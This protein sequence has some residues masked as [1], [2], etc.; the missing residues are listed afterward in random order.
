MIDYA[1]LPRRD[2]LCID[3]KSFFASVEAV[4]RKMHP[5]EAYVIVISNFDRPGAVVLAAS[6]RVKKEFGIKTGSRK[7]EIPNDPRLKIVEPSM[8][9][10]LKVNQ[11]ICDIFRKYVA[12]EDLLIYSIDE[13]L[14]DVSETRQLFGDAWTIAE[15]IQ[16]EIWQTLKLVVAVGIGDNPLLAKLA[17]DNDAKH[18]AKQMAYWSYEDVPNTVWKIPKLT[19]FWGISK[20]YERRL[21]ALSI[22]S[23]YDLAHSSKDLLKARMGVLGEQL[24]YHSHGVDYTRLS[25]RIESKSKSYGKGQTLM[26]D[27]HNSEEVLRVLFELVEDVAQRLRAHGKICGHIGLMIATSKNAEE[28]G[29]HKAFHLPRQT[30]ATG[31]LQKHFKYLFIKYWS[32]APVRQLYVSCDALSDDSFQQMDLF[33]MFKDG[34]HS[35]V[36]GVIDG[37]RERYGKTSVFK[38]ANLAEGSSFKER[39]AYVGG[40]KGESEVIVDDNEAYKGLQSF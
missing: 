3:V 40:H 31:E 13:S 35:K 24:Y 28:K 11:M 17:L 25:E 21:N 30:N 4:R 20:G 19:D 2:V 16:R 27:Y 7:F 39:A 37:L 36:D 12:E 5:L 15:R 10:Y 8:A 23:V 1:K 29:F 18:N 6:P 14:L 32:G 34:K 26:R 22:Y 38:A 9:L 33:S